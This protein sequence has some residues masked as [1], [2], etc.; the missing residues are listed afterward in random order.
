MNVT[1][2]VNS[3]RSIRQFLDK[4]VDRATLEQVLETAQRAPSGGNTQPWNAVV[5][6][7]DAL[8]EITAKI[9]EKTKTARRC[10]SYRPSRFLG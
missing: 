4:P 9:K 6:G 5:V 2:A 1:E 10:S 7:G 3:R 8:K